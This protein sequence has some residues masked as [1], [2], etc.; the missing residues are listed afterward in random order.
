[1]YLLNDLVFVSLLDGSEAGTAEAEE[2]VC[3]L[4]LILGWL[5]INSEHCPP[6]LQ[7]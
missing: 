4:S 6:Y 2:A 3:W 7:H 1:M 5:H